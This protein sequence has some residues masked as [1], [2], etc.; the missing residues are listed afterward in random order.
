LLAQRGTVSEESAESI[1]AMMKHRVRFCIGIRKKNKKK[2]GKV[3]PR[4]SNQKGSP[5]LKA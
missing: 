3:D 1:V 4:R 5:R 2:L